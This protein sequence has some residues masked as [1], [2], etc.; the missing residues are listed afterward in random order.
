VLHFYSKQIIQL[1]QNE[2]QLVTVVTQTDTG[3]QERF[4]TLTSSFYRH[5]HAVIFVYDITNRSSFEEIFGY[6]EEGNRYSERAEKILVANK[7][8][9][10]QSRTVST[11]EGEVR[12]I[13]ILRITLFFSSEIS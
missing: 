2:H 11:K 6:I 1:H 12:A 4:R 7:C 10:E 9:L 13:Y 3:G 8:D 5:A